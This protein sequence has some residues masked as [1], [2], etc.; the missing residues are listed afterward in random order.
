MTHTITY[1]MYK[2]M[3]IYSCIAY[4]LQLTEIKQ[5]VKGVGVGAHN[6]HALCVY[7]M[8]MVCMSYSHMS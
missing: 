4:S 5:V 3:Y 2:Y 7:M 6:L 1:I 8:Y